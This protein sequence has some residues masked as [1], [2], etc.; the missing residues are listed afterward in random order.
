VH[1][2]CL[3]VSATAVGFYCVHGQT[4]TPLDLLPL[5][6]YS[7]IAS[8]IKQR[9]KIPIHQSVSSSHVAVYL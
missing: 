2:I 3:H 1:G 5:F 7:S 6:L 4:L 9:L 8:V